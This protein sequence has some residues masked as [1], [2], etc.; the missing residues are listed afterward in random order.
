[1]PMPDAQIHPT[2][3]GKAIKIVEAHHDP[4]DF[5]FYSGWFCPFV[6]RVW[7]ALEEKGIPYQYKEENP[8]HKDEEFLRV[9]PRGLVPAATYYGKPLNESQV[10]LEFLEDAYPDKGPKLRPE[11]PYLRA[12]MRLTIDHISKNI[13]PAFFRLLQAQEDDKRDE[14]R[15]DLVNALD[16]FGK[17]V[18]GPYWAGEDITFADLV[19]APFSLREYI[20]KEHRGLDDSLLSSEYKAWRD[21]IFKRPSLVNTMSEA[22]YYEEIYDRYLRNEA[23]SE[24]AKGT[25]AGKMNE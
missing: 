5:V 22:K 12:R 11:D 16:K 8:Y 10:I 1:M 20:L 6:Q 18:K 23:Q 2:A 21:N 4:Q 14:A 3:T 13:I 19:L 24:V 9:S 17:E 15:N 25:R 7:A